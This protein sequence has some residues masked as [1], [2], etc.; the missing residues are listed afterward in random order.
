MVTIENKTIALPPSVPTQARERSRERALKWDSTTNLELQVQTEQARPQIV[1]TPP[2]RY[3]TFAAKLFNG[4]DLDRIALKEKVFTPE[5]KVSPSKAKSHWYAR[6]KKAKALS[7]HP[8]YRF[9]CYV[10]YGCWVCS[11]VC[12]A[13][14]NKKGLT[15]PTAIELTRRKV[16]NWCV[17]PYCT[18]PDSQ[19][20]EA[21]ADLMARCLRCALCG[22]RADRC[23]VTEQAELIATFEKYTNLC[24]STSKRW[25]RPEWGI[26]PVINC[27][28][29]DPKVPS[30]LHFRCITKSCS[31]RC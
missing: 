16:A 2:V 5:W 19:T 20:I 8:A 26:F 11:D 1:A 25:L 7:F 17:Y 31:K 30:R 14:N 15:C 29:F 6:S 12:H 21:C 22:H 9:H 10:D 27:E 4:E 3:P 18:K 24:P 28:L 13:K 23:E